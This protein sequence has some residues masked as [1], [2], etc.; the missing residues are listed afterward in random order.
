MFEREYEIIHKGSSAKLI[1]VVTDDGIN[2][3][4]EDDAGK[5]VGD[6]FIG[7]EELISQCY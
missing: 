2:I 3:R 6:G 5:H 4:I 1:I 7:L